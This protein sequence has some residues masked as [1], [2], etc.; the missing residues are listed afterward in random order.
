MGN[1]GPRVVC[2]RRGGRPT[3]RGPHDRVAPLLTASS[4]S[5]VVVTHQPLF[6]PFRAGRWSARHGRRHFARPESCPALE[7]PAPAPWRAADVGGVTSV[8]SGPA[9][10]VGPAVRHS[11]MVAKRVPSSRGNRFVA[12]QPGRAGA[13]PAGPTVP[14]PW[15]ARAGVGPRRGAGPGRLPAS[16]AAP[17]GVGRR[18]AGAHGYAEVGRGAGSAC[19]ASRPVCAASMRSLRSSGDAHTPASI[20]LRSWLANRPIGRG[21]R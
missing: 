2:R 4:S 10:A 6:R 12:G 20:W 18:D 9:G 15:V 14:T 19:R 1:A 11:G 13:F 17:A 7:R 3:G 21:E 8:I 5:A 16:L